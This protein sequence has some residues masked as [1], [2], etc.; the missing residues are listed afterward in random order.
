MSASQQTLGRYQ[1]IREIARSNDIV[2]EGYDPGMNRRV[3]LKELVLPSAGTPTQREERLRR[4]YREAKAAGSLAHPNIVTIYE[5]GEDAGRHFIAMEYLEGRNLRELLDAEGSLSPEQAVPIMKQVLDALG[6]AH[7]H[8]VVH[9]DIKPE[10]IQILADGRVKLTD[11]GIAR[12]TFEQSITIDGQVFGTPSYMSPE[13][14]VGRDLDAR[15]DIFSCGVVLY[16]MLTGAKPFSGDSVV[17]IT[18]AIC[19]TEPAPAPGVPEPLEAVIRKAL[20]KALVM[21]Y[22]SA[23]EMASALDEALDEVKRAGAQPVAPWLPNA[24]ASSYPPP[25]PYTGPTSLGGVHPPPLPTQQAPFPAFPK[26]WADPP[27]PPLLSPRAKHMLG[28]VLLTFLIGAA[29][30]GLLFGAVLGVQKWYEGRVSEQHDLAL[31]AELARAAE[32]AKWDP[33]AAFQAFTDLEQRA[34]TK[35]F[36]QTVRRNRAV[37]AEMEGKRLLRE[38][39]IRPAVEWFTQAADDDPANPAYRTDLGRLYETVAQGV[40][41]RYEQ[42]EA[43]I[44]AA[45]HWQAASDLSQRLGQVQVAQAYS[46][47][48]AE[49]LLA[50]GVSLETDGLVQEA[51]RSYELAYSTASD[52]SAVRE[53]ARRALDRVLSTGLGR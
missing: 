51:A 10:N 12:L 1:I 24:T 37:A 48:A 9:R 23:S 50:V 6:Y 17:S 11:F 36:A 38:G 49:L 27:P 26:G 35:E 3:A 42:R 40:R 21:R 7:R 33:A 53:Q 30:V 47:H 19:H 32:L 39:A 16:E 4:F 15:T 18:Y 22:G 45:E 46:D 52:G 14:V 25:G 43:L 20:Q 28:T 41:S 44:T 8:G 2:Y 31:A 34:R 29:A 13:Q 5:V